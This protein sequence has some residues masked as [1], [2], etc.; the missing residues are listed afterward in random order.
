MNKFIS[1]NK[2][3]AHSEYNSDEYS[4]ITA[5][6][7][8]T[9]KC[10]NACYYCGQKDNHNSS[11]LENLSDAFELCKKL[12]VKGIYFS[13]G[14]EP[15]L[16]SDYDIFTY[17]Q[18]YKS[19]DYGLITNAVVLSDQWLHALVHNFTCVRVSIDAS[20]AETYKKIRG[21]DNFNKVVE[22]IKHLIDI[23]KKNKS[24]ITIGLQIVVNEYNY[25]KLFA[26]CYDLQEMFSDIDYISVRPIE[27]NIKESPYTD[28][29]LIEI[30]YDLKDLDQEFF[31]VK[32]HDKWNQ[33]FTG[34]KEFGFTSCYAS[35]YM[36]TITADGNIYPCCHVT[37]DYAY[38]IGNINFTIDNIKAMYKDY[39]KMMTNRGF[40]PD[41]CPFGCRGSSINCA[42]E[43]I[44]N[45]KHVNFI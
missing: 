44:K 37:C 23:K 6:I 27:S 22:N 16:Y 36:M 3:F 13:G 38:Q 11:E 35:Q 10:N 28:E 33:F 9:N 30:E 42:I 4:P 43:N 12:C 17:I 32:I 24:N 2:I 8:L 45:M 41:I 25:T 31:K 34:K 15:T 39:D 20:D 1:G 18:Q 19:L 5:E 26:I 14:G 21:T 29:Q 7:H 40:N